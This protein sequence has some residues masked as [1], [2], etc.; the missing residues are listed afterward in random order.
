MIKKA[1][2][3]ILSVFVI[4][5]LLCLFFAFWGNEKPKENI[6]WGVAF[7]QMRAKELGLDW[8]EA[9]LAVLDDLKAKDIKIGT[10]WNLLEPEQGKYDFSD[11]DWQIS[12][13]KK[14]DAKIILVMGMKT[15]GWPEC[16][17]PQWLN[18]ASS[19]NLED[20]VL[21]LI[22]QLVSRYKDNESIWAWQ[23][24]NEPFF[25]FGEC[26]EISKETLKKEAELVRLL[27]SSK[28]PVIISDT[29]EFSFW[30]KPARLADIVGITIYRKVWSK[31]F[32]L[33]V[34]LAFSPA[35]Y[36]RRAFIIK[37]I[38]NK[39]VI[40]L[41][42]QAEPWVPGPVY[43]ASPDEQKKTMDIGQ[44]KKNIDFAKKT[45]L[46]TFYFWGV[47]WWYWSKKN[48]NQP[49]IWQEAKSLF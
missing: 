32:N 44:F 23:V 33:Y 40:C 37:K 43:S 1:L 45:G 15:P 6:R 8:K 19:Q 11:L 29:G 30:I 34:N 3:I 26:P 17:I 36:A 24:E 35:Y 13:A 28:R 9:Y 10:H 20:N 14:R 38:F 12:E 49:E 48:Q 2:I 21:K 27:D 25:P 7:S 4:V 22:S 46:D 39:D 42:L 5:F 47:E 41:E 16:H 18:A 31:E